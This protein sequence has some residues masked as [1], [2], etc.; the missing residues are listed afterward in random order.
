MARQNVSGRF[1]GFLLLVALGLAGW[2]WFTHRSGTPG[3][4]S[5]ART[6]PS[7]VPRPSD[8]R[9]YLPDPA[10]TPGDVIEGITKDDVCTPG[11]SKK[12]RNVPKRVK[13]QVY[14]QYGRQKAEGICCEVDHLVS[15]EL[16]GSNDVKNLWPELY[17]PRPGAYEKDKVEDHLHHEVCKG[18]ITL[19]EAQKEIARDW[20]EIYLRIR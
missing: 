5:G 3:E 4:T 9:Q 2:Y 14:R 10:M 18:T 15:L 19:A 20:Y 7:I 16:G 1:V 12:V 13:D 11:Y 8:H 17:E 6:L